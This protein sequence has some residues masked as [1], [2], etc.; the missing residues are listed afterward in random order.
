MDSN[1]DDTCVKS[2]KLGLVLGTASI[3]DL[4]SFVRR[5]A[6]LAELNCCLSPR[7]KSHTQCIVSIVG[8]GGVGKTQLSLSYAGKYA[9]RFTSTFWL[10][11]GGSADVRQSMARSWD[12]IEGDQ[13]AQAPTQDQKAEMFRSWLAEPWNDQWMLIFDNYDNP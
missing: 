6:E 4:D 13:S 10:D 11:A 2:Q 5:E 1:S 12:C 8:T 3:L 7:Q 9:H